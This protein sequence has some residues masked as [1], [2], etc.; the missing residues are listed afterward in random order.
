VSSYRPVD[1]PSTWVRAAVLTGGFV[2]LLWVLE[3]VDTA[4]DHRLDEYGVQPR[5]GEGLIGVLAAPLLHAGFDHLGA[6]TLPVLVLGFLVLVSGIG[7]GLAVTAVIWLVA[8]L[9]VWLVA[10]SYSVHLGASSLIFG[11]LVYLMAR[12]AFSRRPGEV[13][14]GLT[15]FFLYGGLLFG[16]LP[17]QPGISWQGHLFGAVGG[18]LAAIWL[19]ERR[20]RR[21][22]QP[23]GS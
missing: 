10:P 16:V 1:Q 18:L 3:I 9:G 15:L 20:E 2:A 22:R 4:A 23:A 8:G 13:I 7:R 6:N 12:G 21:E 14:L 5:E 19:S 17:G 11:W